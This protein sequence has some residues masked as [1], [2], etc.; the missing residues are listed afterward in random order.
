M[1]NAIPPT[2]SLHSTAS[3]RS[4]RTITEGMEDKGSLALNDHAD[5]DNAVRKL[6]EANDSSG[7]RPSNACSNTPVMAL[8]IIVEPT[9]LPI[10]IEDHRYG[11]LA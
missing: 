11:V 6:A 5:T 1:S 7:S 2:R 8:N 10:T 4:L 3:R 9:I